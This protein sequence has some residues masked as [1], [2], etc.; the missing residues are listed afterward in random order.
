MLVPSSDMITSNKPL[1]PVTELTNPGVQWH[2]VNLRA[3]MSGTVSAFQLWVMVSLTMDHV[4]QSQVSFSTYKKV[5]VSNNLWKIKQEIKS[6]TSTLGSCGI[7]CN[8]NKNKNV[9]CNSFVYSKAT[10]QCVLTFLPDMSQ[11][12][13][14]EEEGTEVWIKEEG[15]V[16]P[17]K[18]GGVQQL[19]CMG[20][21]F[22]NV[23]YI[24]W[25]CDVWNVNIWLNL[26]G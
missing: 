18:T 23:S 13:V 1:H 11:D 6:T 24:P 4:V 8:K 25:L 19:L 21:V 5:Q 12:H 20:I 22:G 14:V 17:S 26:G 16:Y 10:Q 3:R 2:S 15:L 9:P 7:Q